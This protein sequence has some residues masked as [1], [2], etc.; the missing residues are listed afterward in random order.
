MTDDNDK[1]KAYS[2]ACRE[3]A[4]AWEGYGKR[5]AELR[6]VAGEDRPSVAAL[7]AALEHLVKAED[8]ARAADGAAVATDPD[9]TWPPQEVAAGD[10]GYDDRDPG[11][12]IVTQYGGRCTDCAAV[13]PVG[14]AAWWRPSRLRCQACGDKAADAFNAAVAERKAEAERAAGNVVSLA[15]FRRR[16]A[17]GDE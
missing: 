14:A 17:N 1:R 7:D 4:R 13:L 16:Q 15:D 6:K 10:A 5:L 8:A 2:D 9:R 12:R 11:G 3:R